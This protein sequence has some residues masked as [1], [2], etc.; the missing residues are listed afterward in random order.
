MEEARNKGEGGSV[1]QQAFESDERNYAP[2][3]AALADKPGYPWN[4]SNGR[5]V[6]TVRMEGENRG[7]GHVFP[8]A[9]GVQMRCGG[10]GICAECGR[11][12]YRKNNPE[13]EPVAMD[14]PVFMLRAGDPLSPILIETWCKIHALNPKMPPGALKAAREL[15]ELMTRWPDRRWPGE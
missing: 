12:Y 4:T 9:D 8:R 14:E 5:G 15:A 3:E 13:P 6:P 10:P 11:G 7:H 2:A 1:S